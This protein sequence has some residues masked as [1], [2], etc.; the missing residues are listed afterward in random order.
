MAEDLFGIV[1]TVI[2]SAYHVES[3]VAEGGFGIVYRAHHGGFR[4]PVA[5]K[6]LKVPQHLG[7]D[8]RDRFLEQFH[9]EAQVM[10]RLSASIANVVRPLHM[11][12]MTTPK[13]AFVPYMVLEWLE[14]DTLDAILRAR[15]ATGRK[16]LPL[17]KAIGLLDPAARAL[18]KAHHFEGA[19]GKEIIAHCDIKP[20]NV[21]IAS[22]GGES[23][24]KILD[25]GVAKVRS[26]ATRAAAGAG[27]GT[28]EISLFTPAYGAP[29]QWNPKQYGETGP[30]TDVWGL[31]LTLVET[32]A[33]SPVIV[34]DH[35]AV[36]RQALDPKR[37]PTPRNH[38]VALS[39]EVESVF[40]R[41]LAVDPR[42]RY[43][44]VGA[45]WRELRGAAA[46]ERSG[47]GGA[48]P[49]IPDLVPIQ[50]SSSGQHKL[51]LP[52]NL[53]GQHKL[54]L[55][56]NLSGQHKLDLPSS[57]ATSG[58]HHLALDLPGN[59]E[60]EDADLEASS[61]ISLDLPA[62]ERLKRISLS[63]VGTPAHA[64]P[65]EEAVI[66]STQAAAPL[67]SSPL[68][69]NPPAWN[70]RISLAAQSPASPLP[71]SPRS[72]QRAPEP[73]PAPPAGRTS[74]TTE[75]DRTRPKLERTVASRLA[76]GVA[77]AGSSI[78]ITLLDRAYAAV[79]GEVFTLGPLRT[80]WVAGFLLLAGLALIV[81]EFFKQD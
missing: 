7:K 12:V 29:E 1:G 25:F 3:V 18:D 75:V 9:A 79:T 55:P 52:R 27:S 62:N 67:P 8:Y 57:S 74:A 36:M 61:G 71:P 49:E 60:F 81:R 56:R 44:D 73:A 63:P 39:D 78:V 51:D 30:W 32:L 43:P 13:G 37:R 24:L 70:D 10:F 59:L 42:E 80:S 40:A 48:G 50:R 22:A 6:C 28:K 66:P 34:G 11:D 15:V 16:P 46:R 26:A 45:F 17:E 58:Q 65:P 20:E 76:P 68:S 77:V 72:P 35:T 23:V 21:F 53:S 4:A 41:A 14:G 33:G 47:A 54:D 69:S 38:G 5:L 64:S 31:A 2:A 19:A